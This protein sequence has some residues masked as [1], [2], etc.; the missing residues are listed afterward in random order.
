M[1]SGGATGR[2]SGVEVGGVG[3]HSR[4]AHIGRRMIAPL[5]I[6]PISLEKV[7]IVPE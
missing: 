1:G 4:P 3:G 6:G 2:E 7:R 5:Q